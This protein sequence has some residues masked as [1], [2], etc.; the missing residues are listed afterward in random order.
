MPADLLAKHYVLEVRI[1][2]ALL[3][4]NSYAKQYTGTLNDAIITVWT[5]TDEE[6]ARYSWPLVVTLHMN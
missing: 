1:I 6:H 5:V 2:L 3:R 4:Q